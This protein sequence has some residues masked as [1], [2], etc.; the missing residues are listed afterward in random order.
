VTFDDDDS[1]FAALGRRSLVGSMHEQLDELLASRDQMEQLLR[2][3]VGLGADLDLDATLHRI[4][5]AAMELTGARYGALGV[6]GSDGGLISFLHSGFDD[7]T[8]RRIGH[9][10]AG[11]GVL[12]VL[13]D[14]SEPLRLDDIGAHPEAVGFPEHHPPLRAFLGVPITIRENKFG[15][16]Y[17]SEPI[18]RS[19]FT[20]SDEVAVGALAA[21]AAV[22]VDNAQLF[23]RVR[24]T[25]RWM[26][27]SRAII[28]ALVSDPDPVAEP[29][30]MIAEQACALTDAEQAIVLVPIAPILP[31]EEVDT[32]VV[33]KAVGLFADEVVGRRVPVDGSTS[34]E[35]FRSG[36][37]LI[38]ESFRHP[39]QAFTDVGR[40]PAIA[41]PLR[42]AQSVLGVLVV[43][44]NES[45]PPFDPSYLELVSD[46]ADHAAVALSLSAGRERARE[47][48]IVA[49][50]ERIAHDLHDHV[51]QRL[52][53]AGLDLQ[54]TIARSRSPEINSRLNRTVDD[55]Q[56]TIDE[57]R[58]RIFA[59]QSR[60]RENSFRHQ[61]Q[62]A[63]ARLTENRDIETSV[64]MSGPTSGVVDDLAEHASS[65]I[66]EAVSN[67][68]R[69]SG[70]A[71]IVVDVDVGDWLTIDVIDDGCGIAADNPRRSGLANLQRHAEL[72]GGNCQVGP[73]AHGGNRVHWAAP[74][75][76][77]LI[78]G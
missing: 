76:N 59:L 16:L 57:I 65:V 70:A 42:A 37:P 20:E 11:R 32:L 27:A 10:P 69:H 34:G 35:V 72:V 49:D 7:D 33:S 50:R 77:V 26:E 71:H 64:R 17:L 75:R 58:S 2:A 40:R 38:T 67:A 6:R 13:L 44:K 74:L 43:A 22:A 45:K 12:G 54:G 68:V 4:V 1:A 36:V 60:G 19:A 41:M 30:Q 53:A 78:A 66:V 5:T 9:L 61:V 23:D 73:A 28:T 29:L 21:A 63:I 15:S 14:R 51:I 62:N 39:I 55:L 24:A 48:S 25:A 46:F 52:F 18:T 8:A 47:L 3:I 56:A 31:G